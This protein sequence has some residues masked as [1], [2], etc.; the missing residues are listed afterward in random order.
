[1]EQSSRT[2]KFQRKRSQARRK[3]RRRLTTS[4][5]VIA[6]FALASV[7]WLTYR[8]P[9]TGRSAS[10]STPP[11][12]ARPDPTGAADTP[13]PAANKPGGAPS[14]SANAGKTPSDSTGGKTPSGDAGGG[15]TGGSVP[16]DGKNGSGGTAAPPSTP[17]PGG[18]GGDPNRVSLTF[19]GDVIFAQNVEAALKANGFDYPYKQVRSYLE[20]ADVTI[21]NLETPVTERGE[22]AD[23]EYAYRSSPK[24]L[25]AFKEAG[26]D[27]VNL[28]N[29]HILDYGTTGLLDT[30]DH[31]DKA[32]IRWFG[33]GRN[34]ELAF[35]PV[36]VEKKGM[37]IAFLG[38]SKVVPTQ[39]WKAGKS[40]PGV[41]DTYALPVPL[42]AIRNAKKQ[43]DL[44]VVVAHWGVERQDTPEKYQKDYARQYIDAGADLVVGG[45]PHVLQ[46]F[47]HY[48]G[49]WI[50]YSLGNFIFTMNENPKTWETVI[51][52]A[53]CSK[54]DGCSLKAVPVLTKLANPEPMGEEA[55]SKLFARLTDISYGTEIGKDGTIRAKP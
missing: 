50:A 48:N 5:L 53:S 2:E 38:F 37:K 11:T 42:E 47:D 9:D 28:A 36:I 55:A 25:P 41:A 17:N 27:I 29:N 8:G 40:R 6:F 35:K 32:G 26:F 18:D 54:T 43:A 34:A 15:K 52:Q 19:V 51:L 1:M 49:K 22:A 23:K 21:A 44:V 30:F 12:D 16:N 24:A 3:N 10:P 33:A 31:L 46:G 39:D 7:L 20:N 45:H 4:A 14:D 13:K